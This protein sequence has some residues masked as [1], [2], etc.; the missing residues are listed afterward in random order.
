MTET[1]RTPP[2]RQ[3]FLI[4]LVFCLLPMSMTH[5]ADKKGKR[6]KRP[7]SLVGI[8][9]LKAAP[10]TEKIR[11]SG[12]AE[13]VTRSQLASRVAGSVHRV[14][15][16][17]GTQVKRGTKLLQLDGRS[18]LLV[19]YQRAGE[20]SVEKAR[21]KQAL[22]SLQRSQSLRRKD[23]VSQQK[24]TDQE[25]DLAAA[26]ARVATAEAQLNQAKTDLSYHTVFAPFDGTIV[27]RPPG[28]G[29]WVDRGETIL[30]LLDS[31][32]VELRFQLPTRF[33][34]QMPHAQQAMAE[35]PAHPDHAPWPI[36]LQATL[37]ENDPETR[38]R[39]T[40]WNCPAPCP[41][42][43]GQSVAMQVT[44]NHPSAVLLPKDA[45]TLSPSGNKVW[46]VD[47]QNKVKAI[48]VRSGPARGAY[49]RIN[50]GLT[51]GMQVVVN[52][53]ERLRPKQT[54]RPVQAEEHQ[55]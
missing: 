1:M 15:H 41:A 12:S 31:N 19:Q 48:V 13:A 11:F 45:L 46:V 40:L 23:V 16:Q 32:H 28:P 53:N 20:L 51:A 42:Q 34:D 4:L 29:S 9:T 18:A 2:F 38:L 17:L 55:P 27:S 8:T 5:A 44:L 14:Y 25:A 54:V 35:L 47:D 37:P 52:G 30:T 3:V 26:R 6:A 36:S 50:E 24:I 21:L 33:A 39:T 22:S 43:P 10:A 49:L 7:P